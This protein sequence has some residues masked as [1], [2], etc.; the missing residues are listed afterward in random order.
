MQIKTGDKGSSPSEWLF[1]TISKVSNQN[2]TLKKIFLLCCR[3]STKVD[4][5]GQH[6]QEMELLRDA[7]TVRDTEQTLVNEINS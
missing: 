2:S 3:Q 7:E 1:S 4:V 6:Q 5:P